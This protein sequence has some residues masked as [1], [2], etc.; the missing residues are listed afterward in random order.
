LCN[1]II[2]LGSAVQTNRKFVHERL[3]SDT[4]FF[5]DKER[6]LRQWKLMEHCKEEC[7][8]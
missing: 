2:D 7:V 3:D 8:I 6:F 4:H 1:L 5:S